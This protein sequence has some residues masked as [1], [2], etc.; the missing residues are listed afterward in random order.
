[1]GTSQN[2]PTQLNKRLLN[3]L[4]ALGISTFIT[5]ILG[6]VKYS[7]LAHW[8]QTGYSYSI[9]LSDPY[10][11]MLNFSINLAQRVP[12]LFTWIILAYCIANLYRFEDKLFKLPT[13]F[14]GSIVGVLTLSAVLL[15]SSAFSLFEFSYRM[16]LGQLEPD[17]F[18]LL[19]TNILELL[20]WLRV[21]PHMEISPYLK[22][23]QKKKVGAG[24]F[25][26]IFAVSSSALLKAVFLSNELAIGF[27]LANFYPYHTWLFGIL[28][29]VEIIK[30]VL[31]LIGGLVVGI[32]REKRVKPEKN[33]T[34]S[35]IS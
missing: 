35:D 33:F 28:A 3:L 16:L 4:L 30:A 5:S 18:L 25:I 27:T 14:A 13:I 31:Y 32:Y 12:I 20:I 19:I 7:V 21:R 26:L 1:M 8:F 9:D 15:T 10:Y 23:K 24:I 11:T 34:I 29:G 6:A 22:K 2:D 17:F